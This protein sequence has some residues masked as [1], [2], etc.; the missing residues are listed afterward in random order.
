VAYPHSITLQGMFFYLKLV[1]TSKCWS[2]GVYKTYRLVK[3]NNR[4][5][6]SVYS[7]IIMSFDP[8]FELYTPPR[9]TARVRKPDDGPRTV[10]YNYICMYV[11]LN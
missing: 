1:L 6:L 3:L 5:L 2:G 9:S 4:Q 8:C 11:Y 7:I 10:S